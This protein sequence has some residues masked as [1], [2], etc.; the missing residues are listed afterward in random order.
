MNF[1]GRSFGLWYFIG[2]RYLFFIQFA[3]F[4]EGLDQ[5]IFCR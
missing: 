4:K 2:S 1:F 3:Y 5:D